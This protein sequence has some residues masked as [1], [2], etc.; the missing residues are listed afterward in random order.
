MT[1]RFVS[2]N[3]SLGVASTTS[4][5]SNDIIP[6]DIQTLVSQ[7]LLLSTSTS[8]PP[9]TTTTMG[10]LLAHVTYAAISIFYMGY[11]NWN[12]FLSFMEGGDNTCPHALY[13]RQLMH[14][15]A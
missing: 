2:S 4:L 1:R 11:E 14:F 13:E 12:T 9:T 10:A 15:L 8:P 3:P 5:L 7:D 6:E